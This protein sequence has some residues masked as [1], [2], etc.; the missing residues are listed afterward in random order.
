MK[1]ALGSLPI[2]MKSIWHGQPLPPYGVYAPAV[3]P[4]GAVA[5]GRDSETAKQV[6]SSVEGYPGDFSYRDFYRDVGFDLDSDYV[7]SYLDPYG[8]KTYT[9]LK[10]Y[11]VTGKSDRKTP[12]II[13]KAKEKAREHA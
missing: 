6:W 2:N 4:S 10:Y 13:Q 1:E 8:A 5:F 12:Y 11:R 9:G 3:C 7:K